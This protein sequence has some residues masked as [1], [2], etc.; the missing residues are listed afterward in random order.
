M[1]ALYRSVGRAVPPQA[2]ATSAG[3]AWCSRC[4][5]ATKGKRVQAST[6]PDAQPVPDG[7]RPRSEGSPASTRAG[8]RLGGCD[9]AVT[10]AP[11]VDRHSGVTAPGR[12]RLGGSR[13][14]CRDQNRRAAP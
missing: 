10:L 4:W 8:R 6:F 2:I 3:S 1:D 7:A 13:P 11:R 9:A 5:T 12:L 14:C